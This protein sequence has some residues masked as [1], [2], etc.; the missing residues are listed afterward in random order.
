MILNGGRESIEA[1]R[2]VIQ[3]EV[4]KKVPLVSL[5][6]Y[7]CWYVDEG[8]N[9]LL[10]PAESVYNQVAEELGWLKA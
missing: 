10:I 6:N 8:L 5:R 7:N 1:F 4:I 3:I 2:P 9:H